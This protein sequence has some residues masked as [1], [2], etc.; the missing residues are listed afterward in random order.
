MILLMR[1]EM[2]GEMFDAGGKQGDLH[3]RGAGIVRRAAKVSN[4]LAGLFYGERHDVFL[5]KTS[6]ELAQRHRLM[7]LRKLRQVG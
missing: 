2:I 6:A 7:T 5:E 1:L 3:F 4:D